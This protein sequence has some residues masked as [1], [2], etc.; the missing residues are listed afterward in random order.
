VVIGAPIAP[1]QLAHGAGDPTAL[2]ETLRRATYALS[3]RPLRSYD[4]GY[5]FEARYRSQ[6][7]AMPR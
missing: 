5:E 4:P 3:P 6:V 7:G 1:E 2:M